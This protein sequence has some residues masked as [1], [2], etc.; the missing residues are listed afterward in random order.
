MAKQVVMPK[1]GMSMEEGTIVL[2]HKS[3]GD[4]V[5][6][7]EALVSISSEKIE[8]EVESPQD[9]VLLKIAAEVDETVKVG[10]VIGVVGQE[11]ESADTGDKQPAEEDKSS[12]ATTAEPAKEKTASE[13][14]QPAASGQ[15]DRRIRVSPAA[16]KLAKEKGVDLNSVTGT[17]PKGRVTRE[18]ILRA[19]KEGGEE[20]S[21]SEPD[22]ASAPVQAPT[23]AAKT[24]PYS[25]IRKVIGERMNDSIH[26]SAQ[27]TMMRY[28]HVTKLMAFRKETNEALLAVHGSRK[29]TVTDLV[30]RAVVLA[31][32]KHPFM[33]SALV[34]ET[35]YEYNHVHLGIA[36]SMERGLMVPVV[37][38]AHHLSTLALSGAIRSLGQ[39]TKDNQLSQDEM[40]G[41]TFTITNLGASGI[42]FFTPILNTPETGILGVG[43]G[44]ETLKLKDGQPVQS[45]Q[46]PLSLTFDHRVVDGEPA[47]QFFA[48]VVNLLEEP[49]ALITLD[50]W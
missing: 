29:L 11:G 5:K 31:L 9:G 19:A 8:N 48:T 46:L 49:H 37:K 38:D 22:Q 35:I 10:E 14:P 20:P 32:L 18:D 43:A 27:L 39:K 4:P 36:A 40:K 1:M 24:R 3:E 47:S 25:N 12:V 21:G 30:A 13:K 23:E 41:S 16:K 6:K 7:G 15:E 17:G 26:Q 44:E 28:A 33:N 34:N 42:G 2:W 45:I 50:Q